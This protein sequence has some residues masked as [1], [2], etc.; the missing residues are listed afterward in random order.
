MRDGAEDGSRVTI[1]IRRDH[2]GVAHVQAPDRLA[3]FEAQGWVA[4]DDRIWQMDSARLK[5]QGR[6][7]EIVGHKGPERTPF[8]GVWG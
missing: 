7:A 5:A 4:A 3:A 1:D 2:W 6:W 8:L